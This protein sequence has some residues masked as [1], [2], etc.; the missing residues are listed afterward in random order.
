MKHSSCLRPFKTQ[1]L[2]LWVNSHHPALLLRCQLGLVS[3]I[4]TRNV[5]Y[6]PQRLL[7]IQTCDSFWMAGA[8]HLMSAEHYN[9]TTEEKTAF[10]NR[11]WD[12]Y[13]SNPSHPYIGNFWL[14]KK[15]AYGEQVPPPH[16]CLILTACNVLFVVWQP[17][18]H[19]C[20]SIA[21]PASH[22]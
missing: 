5:L 16:W 2:S 21:R 10:N 1:I 3:N 17:S 12:L 22:H 4:S 8:E 6:A 13:K 9:L 7:H 20:K 14:P 18:R 19:S 11:C 15:K